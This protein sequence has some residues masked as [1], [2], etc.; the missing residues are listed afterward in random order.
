MNRQ[1][2]KLVT[3][4]KELFQLDQP[5]LDFGLY[6]IMH[7]KADEITQF[8]EK[9]LL[10]QV[11]DAFGKYSTADK[12]DLESQLKKAIEQANNLGVD[13][14]TTAKVKELRRR[15]ADE[16]VDV[17]ALETEVY[18]HLY[19]FFR[20][21]YDEGDFLA[22]RVYKPGV[23]AIPYEGEEV[24]LHWANRDQYY[25]KTSEYLRDYAFTLRPS[26]VKDPMRVHF[27]LVDVTEGEHGN[28]KATEG[29]DRAFILAADDFINVEDGEL[30]LRFQYRPATMS[31]W[32]EGALKAATAAA[33]KKPP[34]QKELLADAVTRV[35]AVADPGFSTWIDELSKKHVKANG[36][37][38]DYSRLEG[39]LNRYVARHT[40]DY[41]I[42]KD[43]GG[44][45]RRELDF[46]I[47]NEIMHLD[48]VESESAA[49][50]DQYLS[51]LKVIRTIARKLIDFLA[52]LEAFQKKMWLKRKFVFDTTY[53]LTL[54]RIPEEFY[55]EIVGNELQR[56][57][58]VRLFAID[59][60]AASDVSAGYSVPL[61]VEFLRQ[62]PF[63]VVDTSFFDANF[64]ARLIAANADLDE[65][66]DDLLVHSDNFQALQLLKNRYGRQV[67]CI[68]IDPPYNTASSAIPYKNNYKHSSFASLMHGR[69]EALHTFLRQD[70]A[71]F[72]SIDKTERTVLQHVLDEVFGDDNRVEELIWSMNTNNSQ[73]PN[74]S[75][76]HEYVLA[77]AKDRR[78]AEQDKQMFREPKPG[79]E[80]VMELVARLNPS[81][82]AI[83]DIEAELRLLYER[84][85]DEYREEME[86]AGLE[87]EDV[88]GDD[89][90]K[91]LFNYSRAEYRDS[92]GA[93]VEPSEAKAKEARI[94]VWQEGDA[95]MPATKQAAST[96]DP[97][98]PNWRFY[99]PK[100][101][102]TGQP[103]PHPK[104]GWK[105]A[106]E[107]GEDSPDR[108]SFVSLDQDGRIAWG[109]DETKVP[110]LKRMLHEVETNVG[111]SVFS[112]YSDG[113]KQTSAMFG[114]SGVFLSPKHA[115]FV[116]RFV[117][118]AGDKNCLVLDCFGGSGSTT[119]S[120]IKLNREDHG[121]RRSINVEVGDYFDSVLKPRVLKAIYS[122]DWR[123]GK[124]VSRTGISRTVKVLRLESYEDALNNLDTRRTKA[125][126][127]LLEASEAAGAGGFKEE[128][129]LRYML[130]VETRGSQSL[131][132]V[133]AF[134][135]PTGYRLKVKAPGSDQSREVN[136]NLLETFNY[137]IGLTVRHVAAPQAFQAA[138]KRDE[139]KRL[140][141]DGRLKQDETG[142]WWFRTV[143]GVTPDGRKALV[144]WRKLT[145][146]AE[147]DNL[148]LDEWFTRQGY[149][150]KD[151][152]FDLIFVN[153]DNNLENLRQPD[154]TWKVRLI[155]E[156][157]H[158][159]MF[160]VES[161]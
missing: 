149:S 70:G 157:F 143:D 161:V 4:L 107:S 112:D 53:C 84:H 50:V 122:I 77:Y 18:D 118:H 159:L 96:R 100:H 3:L 69:I 127:N 57:E 52:Q 97:A 74:Y 154:A 152:E 60:I 129:L 20:R 44:F 49:R 1:F 120:V 114:R 93:L 13:P 33:A 158:R 95:S 38:A 83:A 126:A 80:E 30:V 16:S 7:A 155:E 151:N 37:T 19:S 51:K 82:P 132:N 78:I 103:C 133:A 2:D 156:D 146:N 71:I 45:L 61:T 23:Y 153:G 139:E 134:R 29:R 40:F 65:T 145:G 87:W 91:G 11:K 14:E 99:K 32:P 42:H 160:D 25:I 117:V 90:W 56:E 105:F 144:I 137:L 36:D 22:K 47:K 102:V 130:D 26:A 63:L 111:K 119:H 39:H 8:L 73:A 121:R 136:V 17:S 58:W 68:Y 108:R 131:L 27:R 64:K 15:I 21:Y 86:A 92:G 113:E 147:Q 106:Y 9:D 123:A 94:W 89:P 46:F 141:L 142:P 115:D 5:D 81:F 109:E 75:T 55:G 24:K 104:S 67:K 88:K 34:V 148:V 140:Q 66:T 138:F 48:D 12:T 43:L 125:Q 110:R 101:P 85:R 135:D 6:R 128:Y 76:N 28:V 72:V 35:L 116:S 62:N 59:D 98:H 150:T 10:P 31:D 79:Y 124:P 41:F 54:D